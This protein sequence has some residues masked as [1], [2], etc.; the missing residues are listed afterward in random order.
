MLVW[1]YGRLRHY[2]ARG[3]KGL[4]TIA[5]PTVGD[6]ASL[7]SCRAFLPCGLWRIEKQEFLYTQTQER[8]NT[9]VKEKIKEKNCLHLHR[10]RAACVGVGRPARDGRVLIWA[11]FSAASRRLGCR[12]GAG[13]LI[14]A[15]TSRLTYLE[16]ITKPAGSA[17][18]RQALTNGRP[19]TSHVMHFSTFMPREFQQPTQPITPSTTP[20]LAS[21]AAPLRLVASHTHT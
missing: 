2:R 20:A 21:D 7:T 13:A 17:S 4:P 3:P 12:W 19:A 8:K 1:L 10:E 9:H 6:T 14:T 18:P 11:S 5:P 16:P 15:L